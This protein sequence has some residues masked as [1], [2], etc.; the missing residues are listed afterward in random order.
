M[1]PPCRK[2]YQLYPDNSCGA[3]P[4]I[5]EAGFPGKNV[6]PATANMLKSLLNSH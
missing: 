2:A 1:I 6:F 4:T 5:E 3:C